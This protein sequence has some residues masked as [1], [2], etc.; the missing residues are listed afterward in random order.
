MSHWDILISACGLGQMSR[1]GKATAVAKA[2][3]IRINR[4]S[5]W[6]Q[7]CQVARMGVAL[8]PL[9]LQR[10]LCLQV[11]PHCFQETS[12]PIE[13]LP[14]LKSSGVTLWAYSG[15][16][17][18]SGAWFL[19]PIFLGVML[20]WGVSGF[21]PDTEF[22]SLPQDTAGEQPAYLLIRE[23]RNLLA[24]LFAHLSGLLPCWTLMLLRHMT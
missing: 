23:E 13:Y 6:R 3:S 17:S 10:L 8:I 16:D 2:A 1:P 24:S 12:D 18:A 11:L 22:W 5:R 7:S 15:Q 9:S 20:V 14:A 4:F 21:T 19:S